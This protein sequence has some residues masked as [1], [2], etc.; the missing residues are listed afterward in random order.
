MSSLRRWPATRVRSSPSG[1]PAQATRMRP[2]ASSSNLERLEGAK[3]A[4]EHGRQQTTR[5]K[6]ALERVD[7]ESKAVQREEALAE[8][9]D[10]RIT[11][12]T[13]KKG[14]VLGRAEAARV[15]LAA[16]RQEM[17]DLAGAQPQI[18]LPAAIRDN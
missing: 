9:C 3:N 12:L 5:Q 13:A 2:S 10:R 14:E 16:A 7:R 18:I 6:R 4:R 11:D 15:N 17:A 1:M 8:Y